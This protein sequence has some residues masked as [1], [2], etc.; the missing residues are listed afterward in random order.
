MKIYQDNGYLNMPGIIE[1]GDTFN[2]CVGGR[3][4]GKTYGAIKYCIENGI[5][6]IYMRRTDTIIQT[7]V[8]SELSPVR[9]VMADLGEVSAVEKINKYV[10]GFYRGEVGEDGTVKPIGNP[11]GIA[12]GLSVMGNLRG[13]SAADYKILINDEFIPEK[14]ER[15]L[16]NEATAFFNAY[17]TINRN[18]ELQGLP[19][20]QVLF[21]ANAN[22]LTNDYFLTL[23]VIN[24]VDSMRING[25][26]FLHDNK[27]DLSI[28][29]LHDS[30]IS[31][32]KQ[33]TA[34]YRL[35]QGTMYSSMALEND[36]VYEDRGTIASRPLKEYVA[37]VK[38]GELVI[39]RHKSDESYYC[40]LHLS[41]SC[42]EYGITDIE[43]KRFT[44][45]YVHLWSAYL[46]DNIIFETYTCEAL[47]R[48]YFK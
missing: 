31:K 12:V 35:T 42:P 11:L 20:L 34:L 4:I 45:N 48:K 36:F 41:G 37:V 18:R 39:Y 1:R 15:P 29:L 14:H 10:T 24:R 19:P 43:L 38:V 23:N 33:N 46:A 26:E 30:P 17:E 40:C 32:A 6:F 9:P 25:I 7:I 47:F 13:W 8:N 5:K 27:R 2:F 21:L 22:D 44:K 3:G 28:Y 16:K